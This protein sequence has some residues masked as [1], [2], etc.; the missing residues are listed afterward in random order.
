MEPHLDYFRDN[1][2]HFLGENL[3]AYF[4]RPLY[5]TSKN[6]QA[7]T[8]YLLDASY[9]RL[10]NIQL[11]YSLPESLLRKIFISKVRLYVSGENLWTGTKMIKT[12]DPE[13]IEGGYQ[14][15]GNVYPLSKTISFGLN[16]NF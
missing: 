6:Q 7:Q 13:T 12:F 1:P 8:R 3:N 15:N 11:G 10:K 5:N 4:P 16:L 2:D 9:I 14:G